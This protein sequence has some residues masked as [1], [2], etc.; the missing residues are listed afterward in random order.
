[1]DDTLFNALVALPYVELRELLDAVN[2]TRKLPAFEDPD[3]R[4]CVRLEST[5][6]EEAD[7]EASVRAMMIVDNCTE[8]RARNCVNCD[9][10][11]DWLTYAEAQ[12]RCERLSAAAGVSVFHVNPERR[13]EREPRG[14]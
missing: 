14:R 4:F 10:L 13:M 2:E 12:T 11:S 1:M 6:L 8:A 9:Y 5:M 3:G 7:V